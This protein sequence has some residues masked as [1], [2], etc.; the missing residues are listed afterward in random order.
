MSVVLSLLMGRQ[1]RRPD[2]ARVCD[3]LDGGNRQPL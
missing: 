2:L 1:G 3:S